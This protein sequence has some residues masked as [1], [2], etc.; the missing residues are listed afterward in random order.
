MRPARW[1][2]YS[3][4]IVGRTVEGITLFDAPTN[5]NHPAIF[6]VRNDG[7]MG[8]AFNQAEA[9]MLRPGEPLKRRHGFFLHA[10][11]AREKAGTALVAEAGGGPRVR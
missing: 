3:G 8:A 1:V 4:P 10:G 11:A 5:P 6:H 9:R 2:D 7:W